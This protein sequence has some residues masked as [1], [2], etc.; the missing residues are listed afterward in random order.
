MQVLK[1]V[2][3]IAPTSM[4]VIL[5]GES[6]T[7][8]EVI[9]HMIHQKSPRKDRS[10]VAI[11]CGAIPETLVESELFGYQKGAFTGADTQKE[12]KFEQA[13]GGTLFLD[14]IGNLTEAAQMKLLRVIEEKKIQRLGGK[15][16]IKVAVRII[17]ATNTDLHKAVKAGK[18]RDDLFHRLNEFHINLPPLRERK[19]DIPVLAKHFL[20]EADQELNRKIKGFS[21]ETIKVLLNYHWPGNV[22]ELKNVI[23]R[24]VLLTES[25]SIMP[26]HLSIDEIKPQDNLPKSFG[27]LGREIS[28]DR[29][30]SFGNIIKRVERDLIEKA[31]KEA[32][33]HKMKAAEILQMNRKALYRK[34]KSLGLPL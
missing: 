10:F 19:E 27:L 21:A 28:L 31:L 11:D 6:G 34:M 22:R 4:T 26:A 3:I 17:V 24:A 23:K 13:N 8:K 12:G 25:D 5:Q 29:G 20:E 9:A 16:D 7:G 33:G 18:F 14:E 1:Q 15:K 30:A 32:G 2:K